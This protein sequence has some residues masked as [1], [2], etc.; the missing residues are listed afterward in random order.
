MVRF[1][2][3]GKLE[4]LK[5]DEINNPVLSG[6]LNL[7]CIISKADS[8]F[9]SQSCR[10]LKYP[11]S[12]QYSHV[13][14]WLGLYVKDIFPDM[15]V[16]PHA[17]LVSPYFQH[18]KSLLTGAV[19]LKDIDVTKLNLVTAKGLYKGFSSTFP[20]P[21]V[22]YKYDVDWDLVWIRQ[23]N[24]VLTSCGRMFSSC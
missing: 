23:Q 15:G 14:Y 4:K 21:K 2:W 18:M 3:V 1:L 20:P 6:G 5:I 13:K 9:L 16:G 10:L 17:E 19:I 22:V 12:K 8:L 11:A 24:P 7:P